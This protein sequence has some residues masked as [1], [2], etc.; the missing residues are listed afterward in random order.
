M[1]ET[2]EK[3][4]VKKR[5]TSTNKVTKKT[6]NSAKTVKQKK[7]AS[8]SSKKIR[9]TV[10]N[11]VTTFS[12][13]V[14]PKKK[15]EK[16]YAFPEYYDLPYRYN[17]TVIKILAQ[18][19]HALFVYWDIS[20]TDRAEMISKYGNNFFNETKPVLLVHNKTLNSTYEIEIDDFTNSWYLRTPTSN[21]VFKIELCRKKYAP[22]TIFSFDN[23]SNY[24]H[25]VKS[26]TLE[27]PNDHILKENLGAVCFKNVKTNQIEKRDYTNYDMSNVYNL[28]ELHNDGNNFENNPSSCFKIS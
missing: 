22:D 6:S 9:D 26:N 21:C 16:N 10:D 20:D 13:K 18:T 7:H 28:I 23:N 5:A 14:L 1:R 15:N 25:I 2:K 19:P 11:V 8:N 12:K 24:M 27:S 17:Q 3:S 4:E